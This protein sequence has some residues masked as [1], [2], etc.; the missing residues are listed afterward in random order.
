MNGFTGLS[1][2][3]FTQR[4]ATIRNYINSQ[5]LD[6]LFAFSDEYRPDSTLYLS[7]YHPINVIE[8]SPQGVYIPSEGD[9]VL[10]LGAIN[11]VTARGI[12]WI[13]DIR[14][15]ETLGEFFK[16]RAQVLRRPLRIGLVGA[17]LLPLKYFR[18]LRTAL[19]D[20]EFV[21][22]DPFLHKMRSIKSPA[23]IQLMEQAAHLGDQALSAALKRLEE[24]AV[25]ENELAAVAEN[26]VRMGGA[27]L[28]SATILASGPNTQM[29]TWRMTD[30]SVEVGDPVLL[31]VNPFYKGYCSDVSVTAFRGGGTAEQQELI[32]LS[33]KT[34]QSAIERLQ[35][36]LP[37]S[38]VY[39]HF[40]ECA[41]AAGYESYFTRYAKG[42]R[43]VGHGVGIN[44]VEWPNLDSDSEFLLE[45]GMTLALKFDLHG[46]RFGGTRFEVDVVI[47]ETGC[48]SLNKILD[49][50]NI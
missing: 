18:R 1:L 12:S 27:A 34:I 48:R 7:D 13:E 16:D 39:D 32:A 46:F 45:A 11:A 4:V 15:V 40:R 38:I 35:P 23:E 30:R 49:V 9:V 33:K 44:V 5:D 42:M 24:G 6:A 36:G 31:D 8:E 19:A 10:F 2:D 20:Q 29:P 25:T 21:D 14:S 26:V 47:E 43:A 37:A 50:A 3:H 28:G 17:A 41:R 22:A